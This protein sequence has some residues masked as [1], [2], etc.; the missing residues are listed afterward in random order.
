MA[1][2]AERYAT[3]CVFEHSDSYERR[4]AAPAFGSVGENL[5]GSLGRYRNYQY[6]VFFDW[7]IGEKEHYHYDT[8]SCDEGSVCGHYKQVSRLDIKLAIHEIVI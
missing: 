2:F 7:G 5:H 8:N 1:N 6:F 4:A 3:K